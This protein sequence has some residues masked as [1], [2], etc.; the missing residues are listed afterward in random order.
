MSPR[1]V[2]ALGVGAYVGL[3]LPGG[4]LGV[5]WPS[6]RESFSQP[7]AALGLLL[8]LFTVGY[9]LAAIAHGRLAERVRTGSF[10]ATF[11]AMGAAG[12]LLFAGS[13]VW[14]LVLVASAMQGAAAAG[15]DAELNAYVAVHHSPRLLQLMHGGFGIGATAGPVLVTAVLELGGSWRV[16]Y[17]AM[18]GWWLVTALAFLLTR[19]RWV[20]GPTI[21]ALPA[22]DSGRTATATGRLSADPPLTLR[23][24]LAVVAGLCA[25]FFYNGLEIAAGTWAFTALVADGMSDGAAAWSVTA[26]WAALTA[27]RLGLGLLGHRVPPARILAVSMVGIPSATALL[28]VGGPLAV[29]GLVLLG[30]SLAGVFPSLVAL[31]PGRLGPTRARRLMGL[32]FGSAVVGAAAVS[33]VVGVVAAR[34]GEEAIAPTLLVAAVVLVACD[35]ALV[36]LDRPPSLV[37][38][39]PSS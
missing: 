22:V 8:V 35:R 13:P 12:S 37:P 33:A 15:I 14:V 36:A 24:R 17:A 6:L 31:T 23:I 38:T 11:A 28:L 3:G 2:A 29:T 16:V 18:G 32:Q 34:A 20:A 7:L 39:P 10:L 21:A 26:F 19:S 1:L 4:A 27:G 5:V 9:L 30:A 25:F